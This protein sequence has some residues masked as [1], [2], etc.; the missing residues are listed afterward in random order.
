MSA[1]SPERCQ[2]CRR[3]PCPRRRPGR[4]RAPSPRGRATTE[5]GRQGAQVGRRAARARQRASTTGCRA[6]SPGLPHED[7][8][9]LPNI[10]RSPRRTARRARPGCRSPRSRSCCRRPARPARRWG[11][12]EHGGQRDHGIRK[13]L[14]LDLAGPAPSDPDRSLALRTA[15]R[16]RVEQGDRVGPRPG[17][18]RRGGPVVRVRSR[19]L[20]PWRRQE[21][22]PCLAQRDSSP[23]ANRVFADAP[24]VGERAFRLD[25]SIRRQ[26][27]SNRS[28]ACRLKTT[29]ALG[30]SQRMSER[31]AAE[32]YALGPELKPSPSRSSTSSC[33]AWRRR[34]AEARRGGLAGADRGPLTP[35]AENTPGDNDA[36]PAIAGRRDRRSMPPRRR[37]P[38]DLTLR[39]S[40]RNRRSTPERYPAGCD[41]RASSGDGKR[42]RAQ[43]LPTGDRRRAT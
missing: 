14:D 33:T 43:E 17:G 23:A 18:H 9:A 36:A 40:P 24:A 29:G 11:D 41:G 5:L 38:A 10:S 8:P 12:P 7:R 22:G 34:A 4:P 21:L 39:R 27:S 1:T 15:T 16:R 19:Q 31:V 37:R 26:V 25:R 42:L 28:S 2:R 35:F 3:A 30:A 20:D 6:R 13:R 32:P